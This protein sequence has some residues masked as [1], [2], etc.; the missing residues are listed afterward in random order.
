V[1]ASDGRIHEELLSMFRDMFA[2]RSLTPIPTPREF[3]E[4]REAAAK[5]NA[6][7]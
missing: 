5:A 4:R 7:T 6:R 2:G 1:L 3:A